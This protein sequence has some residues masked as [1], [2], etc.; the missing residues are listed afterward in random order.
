MNG[1]TAQDSFPH[2]LFAILDWGLGHATRTWPLIVA[3]RKMGARVTVA[4]RGSAGRWLDARMAEWE[5]STDTHGLSP[6][7]RVEKPGVTVRYARGW[8][9]L[10]RIA[11]QMPRFMGSFRRER[12]WTTEFSRNQGVTHVLSDNCYGAHAELEGVSNVLMT[13]QLQ[14]P[15]P[16]AARVLARAQVQRLANAFDAVWVPDTPERDLA[17]SMSAPVSSPTHF[18]GPLS[19]FQVDRLDTASPSTDVDVVLLGLVSGPEPQRS[20]MEKDLRTCFLKDGRPALIFAGKPGGGEHRDRNVLTVHDADDGRF[21]SAVLAAECIICRSGYSTLM[22]LAVLERRGILVPTVGQPEQ[23]KLALEWERRFG[24]T[25][26][27][28]KNIADFSPGPMKG[29]LVEVAMDGPESTM[30]SWLNMPQS[31]RHPL[32]NHD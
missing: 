11:L 26:L 17:G 1:A 21:R 29:S 20:T 23:E 19:R 7:C 6:W 13:H 3:A 24:W 4:S 14:P 31:S 15:V 9:T 22:D 32:C 5:A 8:A 18:I 10:P 28:S 25:R 2:V 16:A 12:Q 30:E 27:Q